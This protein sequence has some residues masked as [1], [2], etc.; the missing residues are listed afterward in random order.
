[1]C[2]PPK[3]NLLLKISKPI[4]K[5]R[6]SF[7]MTPKEPEKE[8]EKEPSKVSQQIFILCELNSTIKKIASELTEVKKELSDS[9]SREQALNKHNDNL[10]KLNSELS[11]DILELLNQIPTYIRKCILLDKCHIQ[12]IV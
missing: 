9:L 11:E 4:I 7:D 12:T 2:L 10:Y 3:N 1:M 5:K 8:P 6:V